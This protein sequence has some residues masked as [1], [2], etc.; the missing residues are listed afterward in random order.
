MKGFVIV[1]ACL[2]LCISLA[3]LLG[4]YCYKKL[5][6]V[7]ITSETVIATV[8]GKDYTKYKNNRDT[9]STAYVVSVRWANGSETIYVDSDTYALFSD[10]DK[11]ELTI[12]TNT[13]RNGQTFEE[14]EIIRRIEEEE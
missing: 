8:T 5:E 1:V 14:F 6:V 13:R 12:K 11:V 2:L 3:C 4:T 9:T 7:D 10:G